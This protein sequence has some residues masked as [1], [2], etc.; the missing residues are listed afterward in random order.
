MERALQDFIHELFETTGIPA[1]VVRIPC[2]D[3]DW[4]DHGLR[5]DILG[6]DGVGER[7]ERRLEQYEAAV[8]YHVTD[9]F[10]CGYTCMR[11]PDAG[12]QYL[13]IGPLL[14]E[15]MDE[16]RLDGLM[17]KLSL[18]DRLHQSLLNYYYSVKFIPYQGL[19]ESFINVVAG[20][21]FGKEQYRVVYNDADTLDEWYQFYQNYLRVPERPFLNIRYIEDRYRIENKMLMAV[22][23]GNE[24]LAQEQLAELQSLPLPQRVP[25]ELRDWKD[26]TITLNTL[27]RKAAEQA[28]VHPIHIDS[29]SN[30][31]VQRIELL[32][33]LEQ[34]TAFGR[35]MVRSYCRLVR[36][37]AL[38]DRSLQ[39]QRVIT[40]VDTNLA[41]DLSLKSLAGLLNINASYLS[42][43]FRREMGMPLTEYVNRRRIAH[44]QRLLLSTDLPIKSIALQSGVSDVYYFSRLFKRLV[45]MTPKAYREQRT[46]ETF[47]EMADSVLQGPGTLERQD[48]P[49][50]PMDVPTV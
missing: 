10:Q 25:N 30:N 43:L 5:R 19:Y 27:L 6:V 29:L 50:A 21:F 24:A 2:A 36:E 28:H 45:G 22:A 7:L 9:L 37:Y 13:L 41:A 49:A 39:V 32:T 46:T 33:S 3:W 12:N 16:R 35:K 8:V 14:F 40:Y 11:L 1:Q 42:A 48:T 20:H 38:K 17:K 34:C 15:Q 18:P 23:A 26:Y 47:S 4:L 44:A 31:N